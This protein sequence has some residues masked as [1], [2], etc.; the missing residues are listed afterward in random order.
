MSAKTVC[1]RASRGSDW[2]ERQKK[3]DDATQRAVDETLFD[4]VCALSAVSPPETPTDDDVDEAAALTDR[5]CL[6]SYVGSLALVPRVV[7][8]VTLCEVHPDPTASPGVAL[9]LD[10]VKI[11]R[12]LRVAYYAPK[13]FA[14]VQIAFSDPRSRVLLFHTGNVVGTGSDSVEAAR[15][16]IT[17]M[18]HLIARDAGVFLQLK[19]FQVINIVA[20]SSLGRRVDCDAFA[21]AHT[22]DSHFDRNSFVGMPWRPKGECVTAE[23]YGT[24]KANLPGAKRVPGLFDSW[25]RMFVELRRF[26]RPDQSGLHASDGSG[27]DSALLASAD[28]DGL[29]EARDQSEGGRGERE[30]GTKRPSGSDSS[31]RAPKASRQ[32]GHGAGPSETT[33]AGFDLLGAGD[34]VSTVQA[35]DSASMPTLSAEQVR[36]LECLTDLPF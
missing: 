20:A 14:A 34:V 17:R 9:P 25:G 15:L 16:A 32:D 11:V 12:S 26:L 13:S 21:E 33:D 23:V 4:Q 6:R 7:N 35:Y 31:A 22:S 36:E 10:M 24:G 30:A 3:L 2:S 18:Q 8:V 19:S 27:T 5:L 29:D 28:I 1:R